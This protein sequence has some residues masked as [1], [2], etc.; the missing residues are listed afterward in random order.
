MIS[1][2]AMVFFIVIQVVPVACGQV[3][4]S[5]RAAVNEWC[6]QNTFSHHV[7]IIHLPGAFIIRFQMPF[8][9]LEMFCACI[10]TGRQ[11][12]KIIRDIFSMTFLVTI[13]NKT[14]HLNITSLMM[15]CTMKVL[16]LCTYQIANSWLS[17]YLLS[18]LRINVIP[19]K[20]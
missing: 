13:A 1:T 3:N 8:S 18:K 5:Y 15:F 2:V 17:L 12:I 19:K 10:I 6:T 4:I 16:K 14:I 7:F 20:N 11:T 9:T